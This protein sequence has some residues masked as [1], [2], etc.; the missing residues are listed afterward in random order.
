MNA[1]IDGCGCEHI[2][3]LCSIHPSGTI[4][5]AHTCDCT[6]AIHLTC[7]VGLAQPILIRKIYPQFPCLLQNFLCA[8]DLKQTDICLNSQTFLQQKWVYL[9]TIKNCS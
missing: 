3:T 4:S 6:G 2:V 7:S 5:K 1:C 8:V 9:G